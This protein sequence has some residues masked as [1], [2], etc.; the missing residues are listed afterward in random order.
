MRDAGD[1]IGAQPRQLVLAPQ[2][3]ERRAD[4]DRRHGKQAEDQRQARAGQATDDELV[5]D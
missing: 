1:K 4:Q 5:G 2:L 3:H